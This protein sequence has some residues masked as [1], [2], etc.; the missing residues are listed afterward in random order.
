MKV[1]EA[2]RRVGQDQEGRHVAAAACSPPI[3]LGRTALRRQLEQHQDIAL[4]R[5]LKLSS[6][7]S[8]SSVPPHA[9]RLDDG[10]RLSTG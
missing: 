10:L 1:L 9:P 3:P 6:E 2:M 5:G 8:H 7:I 4:K